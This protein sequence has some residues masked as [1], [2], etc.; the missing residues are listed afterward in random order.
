MI[1]RLL[2][3]IAVIGLITPAFAQPWRYVDK[4]GRVHYTNDP[5]KLPKNKRKRAQ[6]RL[7]KKKR[8]RAAAQAQAEREAAAAAVASDAAPASAADLNA[9]PIPDPGTVGAESTPKEP[10]P[11]EIWQEKMQAADK[12]VTDL[13]T[14]LKTAQDEAQAARRTALIT[15]S[16]YNS[17]KHAK[18][19]ARVEALE[20]K[21]TDA[22]EASVRTRKAEPPVSK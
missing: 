3:L 16:G 1:A 2:A 18:A 6:E 12:Q 15:P 14:E 10:T 5:N 13:G 11:H 7:E 8:E 21:L 22:Q 9:I 17:D 19:N 4:K 20:K